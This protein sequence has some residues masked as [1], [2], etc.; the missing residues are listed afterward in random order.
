[1]KRKKILTVVGARPQFI[2]AAVV[3]RS[4]KESANLQ[5]FILH[6][7]QHYDANMSEIFFDEMEIPRPTYNLEIGSGSHGRQTG[8]MLEGIEQICMNEKPDCVLVYGDTN[9]TLA[10]ALAAAK[11]HI[12]VAHVESGLRS[13]NRKMPEEINRICTDHLSDLLFTP[14]Q[15]A[16]QNLL[17]EGIQESQIFNNGDVMYDAALFYANR[18]DDQVLEEFGLQPED[19]ILA[20]IH[21]AEN[22][23]N[24]E[25]LRSILSALGELSQQ[26]DVILPLH[27]RTKK[28]LGDCAWQNP[29]PERFK[30]AGPVS[31]LSMIGLEK[32]CKIVATD[33][34]GVQKEAFF[35]KKPCITF[36]DET[37]W[38]ELVDGGYNRIVGATKEKILKAFYFFSTKMPTIQETYYGDGNAGL[39]IVNQLIKFLQG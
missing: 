16:T 36:R 6:T 15:H 38:I 35:F 14:T 3:S 28:L 12:P 10:G 24:P 17:C 8:R 26:I 18:S 20:T 2:K 27:P 1:M 9:S 19:F 4:I 13:W 32:N 7:G 23:D 29:N 21:R 11:L 22:T 30:I 5:E 31:Y 25:R 34:G 33:S 37:E 39:K